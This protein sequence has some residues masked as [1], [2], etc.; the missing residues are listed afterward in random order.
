MKSILAWI[1]SLTIM[2]V[3][4][5]SMADTSFYFAG[6]SEPLYGTWINM[7]Y[8]GIPAQVLI[9][10]PDGTGE[11]SNSVHL[12][13]LWKIRYLIT[14]KGVDPEGNIIYKIHWI[15]NWKWQPEGFSLYKI[16]NSGNTLEYVYD[17]DKYPKEIDPKDSKYRKYTR[18]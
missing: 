6:D 17:S 9:Y 12:D 13:P 10:N 5:N 2:F 1:L 14:G 4:P 3:A 8:H 11:A 15:G 16:S 18:K 7:E